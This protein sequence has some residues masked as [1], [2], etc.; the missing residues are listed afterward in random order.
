MLI[1]NIIPGDSIDQITPFLQA[2]CIECHS[3]TKSKGDLDLTRFKETAAVVADSKLW[4]EISAAIAS[5]EMPPA[6]HANQPTDTQRQEAVGWINS[7]LKSAALAKAGDPGDIPLRRLTNVELNHSL[8][9]LTGL[10]IDWSRDFPTDASGGEGF[11]NAAETLQ[12]SAAL[13]EKYLAVATRVASHAEYLPGSGPLFMPAPT[14]DDDRDSRASQA[15]RRLDAFCA[16]VSVKPLP[17]AA[18]HRLRTIKMVRDSDLLP[19]PRSKP[20]LPAVDEKTVAGWTPAQQ[21]AWR[22]LWLDL[23]VLAE[24]P[25]AKKIDVLERYLLGKSYRPG[26]DPLFEASLEVSY[27]GNRNKKLRDTDTGGAAGDANDYRT[28]ITN[29]T[30]GAFLPF[31]SASIRPLTPAERRDLVRLSESDNHEYVKVPHAWAH[32]EV[33]NRYF[34]DSQI[35]ALW[36]LVSD[37]VSTF[38]KVYGCTVTPDQRPEWQRWTSES[39]ELVRRTRDGHRQNA[40]R[41]VQRAWRVGTTAADEAALG[42]TFDELVAQGR[43]VESAHRAMVIR[44]LASPRFYYRFETPPSGVKASPVSGIELAS[45][46]SFLLWSALPDDEL[47]RAA[48]AGELAD[49]SKL[50]L[51]TRRMM[52]DLRV[53]RFV[54]EFFGQWLGFY[55]F[56]RNARPDRDRFPEFTPTIRQAMFDEAVVF[57]ADLVVNDRPITDLLT[58]KRT[59][60][61]ADLAKFY[62]LVKPGDAGWA[63]GSRGDASVKAWFASYQR[64][65]CDDSPR[66]GVIGWAS[67][68]TKLSHPLRTSP[69]KRG[70]WLLVDVLGTP[71]PKPPNDVP[72]L[73]EDEKNKDGLTQR[74]LLA[75]HR[76]SP[77]CGSCHSRI[78]PLGIAMEQF[79]P[80]GRWRTTD[81][82]GKAINS[83]DVLHNG[84][85]LSGIEDLRTYLSMPA[86]RDGFL[87]LACRKLLGYALGRRLVISDE[88]L[89]ETMQSKAQEQGLTM[90][91]LIDAVVASTQFQSIRGRDAAH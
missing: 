4:K 21:T 11:T 18:I 20:V 8:N 49:P 37:P 28:G 25:R 60:I 19:S 75:K 5:K 57:C 56:D 34:D 61:T 86:Q 15:L 2:N 65:A 51:Q 89:L 91:V 70:N 66:G 72:M 44:A 22:A 39:A 10:D 69:I 71:T 14:L 35:E 77:V 40:I 27:A 6:K 88:P 59:Y 87:A 46:I 85:K 41:F 50:K 84:T 74:E 26:S 90:S 30:T 36:Q 64:F 33:I 32:A 9:D 38:S 1:G 55:R 83:S 79:D 63:N 45:R 47:L 82:N 80:I 12:V 52:A 53:R 73:P 24:T 58:A 68:L 48:Q 13:I 43:S 81:G 31:W 23:E 3:G 42:K 7:T 29:L 17:G 76:E 16:S 54:Q 67:V 78:D 62:G